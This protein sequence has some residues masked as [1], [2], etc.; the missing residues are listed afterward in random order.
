MGSSAGKASPVIAYH[1]LPVVLATG[2]HVLVWKVSSLCHPVG[3]YR[4]HAVG[5][6][7]GTG[8]LNISVPWDLGICSHTCWHRVKPGCGLVPVGL[9]VGEMGTTDGTVAELLLCGQNILTS[10]ADPAWEL[11]SEIP[12]ILLLMALTSTLGSPSKQMFIASFQ[13]LKPKPIKGSTQP[14]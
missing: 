5:L 1:S 9:A 11:V 6:A 10:R 8:V 7:Q 4:S 12:Q 13:F 2:S 14:F 3:C